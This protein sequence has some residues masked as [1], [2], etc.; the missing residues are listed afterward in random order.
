[1]LQEF[2]VTRKKVAWN[3][4]ALRAFKSNFLLQHPLRK[5]CV[6]QI[7]FLCALH[8]HEMANAGMDGMSHPIIYS[9]TD[10][11]SSFDSSIHG[12]WATTVCICSSTYEGHVRISHKPPLLG[13]AKTSILAV[14]KAVQSK[15]VHQSRWIDWL[16]FDENVK[17]TTLSLPMTIPCCL[18][19]S[20]IFSRSSVCGTR[21]WLVMLYP[22]GSICI[23]LSS[24]LF[25]CLLWGRSG[26]IIIFISLVCW[27]WT[28]FS[29]SLTANG[30]RLK[31]SSSLDI[32]CRSITWQ[33]NN[34]S[35]YHWNIFST[36]WIDLALILLYLCDFASSCKCY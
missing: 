2:P 28:L 29:R 31:G 35:Y 33:V 11:G 8:R 5:L 21:S 20:T 15:V 1:M 14:Y 13:S 23:S 6:K 19:K 25:E 16:C 18:Q 32:I 27:P 26:F 30:W 3:L 10:Q 4:K 36:H 24:Q 22:F 34:F 17:A 9:P 12:F 7:V